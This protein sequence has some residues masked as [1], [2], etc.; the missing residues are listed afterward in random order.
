MVYAHIYKHPHKNTTV[1]YQLFKKLCIKQLSDEA[2]GIMIHRIAADLKAI[3]IITTLDFP[4]TDSSKVYM[5]TSHSINYERALES[6][7]RPFW[8]NNIEGFQ[9]FVNFTTHILSLGT[10]VCSPACALKVW[11]LI[12]HLGRRFLLLVPLL[13]IVLPID[14][15]GRSLPRVHFAAICGSSHLLWLPTQF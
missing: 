1:A 7:Y 9:P 15:N 4:S 14:G 10:N 2:G 3:F 8:I 6:L 13:H 12:F 11:V 5:H